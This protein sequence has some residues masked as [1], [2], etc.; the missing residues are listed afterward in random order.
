MTTVSCT[1]FTGSETSACSGW[2]CSGRRTPAIAASTE[3]CPAATM[4]TRPA[5][6]APLVVV[7]PRHARAALQRRSHHRVAHVRRDVDDRAE[8]LHLPGVEP[9]RVDAV[10]PIGMHSTDRLAH[11]ARRVREVEHAALA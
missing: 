4:P 1:G 5:P 3:L 7:A 6:I 2:L 9:F 8:V 10:Q 11:V